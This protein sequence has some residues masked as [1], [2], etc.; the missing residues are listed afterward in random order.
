MT[1]VG[2][3]ALASAAILGLSENFWAVVVPA[4]IGAIG[5][6]LVAMITGGRS[7]EVKREMKPNGGSTLRDAIDRIDRT[8]STTDQ[9]LVAMDE[10]SNNIDTTLAH[11]ISRQDDHADKIE[12]VSGQLAVM[13]NQLGVMHKEI[14]IIRQK[15]VTLGVHI[16]RHHPDDEGSQGI[17]ENR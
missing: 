9:R 14:D 10:R 2:S 11:T 17:S 12:F 16:A 1:S 7:K 6:I 3:D 5:G 4:A 13:H 8:T 15:V